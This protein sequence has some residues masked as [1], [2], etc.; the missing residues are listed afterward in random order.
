MITLPARVTPEWAK[1]YLALTHS[2]AQIDYATGFE[3]RD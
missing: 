1:P 2:P 3:S